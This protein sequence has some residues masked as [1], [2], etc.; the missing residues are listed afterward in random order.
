M[1]SETN[2]IIR[3]TYDRYG[4]YHSLTKDIKIMKYFMNNPNE[5]IR[6]KTILQYFNKWSN[7]TVLRH[8]KKLIK[9]NLIRESENF[10][11]TYYFKPEFI[12]DTQWDM[13]I[14]ARSILGDE[15]F[16]LATLSYIEKE[17]RIEKEMSDYGHYKDYPINKRKP[18]GYS[19]HY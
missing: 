16:E 9:N 2:E 14:L 19:R 13:E 18:M 12:K 5:K 15:I 1:E 11:G 4:T 17:K 8:L 7:K 3:K 6:Q 10:K